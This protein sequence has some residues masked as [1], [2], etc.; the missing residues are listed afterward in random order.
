MAARFHCA[1]SVTADIMSTRQRFVGGGLSSFMTSVQPINSPCCIHRF[2][3]KVPRAAYREGTAKVPRFAVRVQ[4]SQGS[5]M[6]CP[7][8]MP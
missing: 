1:R 8:A 3:V 6:M 5:L 7:T 2:T 4:N